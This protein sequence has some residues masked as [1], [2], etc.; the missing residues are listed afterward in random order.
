MLVCLCTASNLRHHLLCLID[1]ADWWSAP[2]S[3]QER[4]KK[5]DRCHDSQPQG[6]TLAQRVWGSGRFKV[7]ILF[8]IPNK[9]PLL[10][11]QQWYYCVF[12][13]LWP[14]A[15]ITPGP[16]TISQPSYCT[17][18]VQMVALGFLSIEFTAVFHP[19]T[20]HTLEEAAQLSPL[21]TRGAF[22][23]AK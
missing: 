14:S 16:Q 18:A 2:W 20:A 10:F 13:C 22:K 4:K 8:W 12:V 19:Q 17:P 6:K 7:I 21:Q 5:P 15:C 9:K 11:V 23:E 1:W 3:S